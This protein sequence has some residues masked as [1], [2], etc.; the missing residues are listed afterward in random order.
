MKRISPHNLVIGEMYAVYE[1][2]WHGD[3]LYKRLNVIRPSRK[4]SS[5]GVNASALN[6]NT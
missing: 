1:T 6:H 5:L 2:S 4:I 3:K